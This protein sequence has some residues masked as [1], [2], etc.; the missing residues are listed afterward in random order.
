MPREFLNSSISRIVFISTLCTAIILLP[1]YIHFVI[2]LPVRLL[3]VNIKYLLLLY[4]LTSS[5]LPPPPPHPTATSPHSSLQ[6]ISIHRWNGTVSGFTFLMISLLRPNLSLWFA[7]SLTPSFKLYC[8][9]AHSPSM[10]S[11]DS[12][13][14]FFHAFVP[15]P[16]PPPPCILK[17]SVKEGSRGGSGGERVAGRGGIGGGGGGKIAVKSAAVVMI[18]CSLF[19]G[20][21]GPLRA[22]VSSTV[23]T[24]SWKQEGDGFTPRTCSEPLDV[25][26]FVM[27]TRC[28]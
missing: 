2:F 6:L 14:P 16:P 20:T 18:F 25:G 13:G 15:N 10:P 12:L 17:Y 9:S 19:L 26:Y 22:T 21:S 7:A 24:G 23:F 5:A 27:W 11:P 3:L 1:G 28:H 8:H 4:S